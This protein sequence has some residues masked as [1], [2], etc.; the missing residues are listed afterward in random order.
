M[1][2]V[3]VDS[4]VRDFDRLIAD[5]RAHGSEGWSPSPVESWKDALVVTPQSIRNFRGNWISGG[6]INAPDRPR[7]FPATLTATDYEPEPLGDRI[8]GRARFF[9]SLF[10][11]FPALPWSRL[12]TYLSLAQ[13][14]GHG[15]ARRI[16]IPG[17]GRF[18]DASLRYAL[19]AMTLEEL[20]CRGRSFLEIGGGFGGL[21]QRVYPHLSAERYL[22]TDLPINLA[23]SYFNL[24]SHFGPQAVGRYWS[25]ADVA[26]LTKPVVSVAPWL[27]PALSEKIDVAVNTVSFQHMSLANLQYYGDVFKRYGVEQIFHVNRTVRRDP[28]DV[29]PE[30]YP[31]RSNYRLAMRRL[32][33]LS[34]DIVEE[35]LVR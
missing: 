8:L 33:W 17:L 18:S 29:M 35:L 31:F 1:F 28:T 21:C 12:S 32:S 7:R 23:L 4:L 19:Y 15:G 27:L 22:L 14:D 13:D 16:F 20:G 5:A 10:K 6:T 30:D 2:L 9:R 34:S 11:M 25:D 24:A 3:D 26:E